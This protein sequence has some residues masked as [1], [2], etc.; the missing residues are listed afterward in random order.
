VGGTRSLRRPRRRRKTR[1]PDLESRD[2]KGTVGSQ[3]EPH[4]SHPHRPPTHHVVHPAVEDIADEHQL[5]GS[6][7]YLSV[8]SGSRAIEGAHGVRGLQAHL[9]PGQR[10][11][12]HKVPYDDPGHPDRRTRQ[13]D[14]D[15]PQPADPA[16]G[17]GPRTGR[18]VNA[19]R[20]SRAFLTVL[21]GSG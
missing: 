12:A 1:G 20:L 16:P 18:P 21:P 4:I 8:P 5:M 19:A 7:G 14:R 10:P 2:D 6:R 3:V 13:V 17:S 9:R 15:V 11:P